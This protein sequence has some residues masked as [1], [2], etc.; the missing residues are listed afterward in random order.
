MRH[1]PTLVDTIT[2]HPMALANKQFPGTSGGR[3]SYSK[4]CVL[5]FSWRVALEAFGSSSGTAVSG[6]AVGPMVA[7]PDEPHLPV[8]IVTGPQSRQRGTGA[9]ACGPLA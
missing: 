6:R 1:L 4:K 8:Q 3:D 2:V 9:A 5:G 7:H